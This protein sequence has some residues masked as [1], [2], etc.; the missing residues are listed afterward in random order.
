MRWNDDLPSVSTWQPR[1][2][3]HEN[4]R[5]G[6]MIT[7]QAA[8]TRIINEAENER[9][10][11]IDNYDSGPGVEDIVRQELSKLMPR[12]YCVDA[13]VVNDQK[14]NTAGDI[15]VVVRDQTW[16]TAVKLEAT[17]QSRRSH[18]P[19]EAIYAAVEVKQTLGF[20][21]LDVAM[22]KLVTLSRLCRPE[23]PFGHITE[24]QHIQSLNKEG[25]ILNPLHTTVFG[26]KIQDGVEFHDIARRFDQINACL[27]R[28]HMVTM[29]CI[30]DRGTAWYSV[31]SG[32]PYNATFMTDRG[33][34]LILHVNHREPEN[35][36]YRFF[37]LL[38]GHLGRSVLGI[39]ELGAEYGSPPPPRHTI[40]KENALYNQKLDSES[41]RC[42]GR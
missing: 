16:T 37:Q 33:E 42:C 23:N 39:G 18:F 8:Q 30:L 17:S 11:N 9:K 6:L 32:S 29:L 27:N 19:F 20:Q 7:C 13:G 10:F 22:E 2:N 21:Q 1:S 3:R 25:A 35:A 28:D 31:K 15:D 14:G 24:N 5:T 4:L 36:F 26:T 38:L 40:Y 12:R 41:P 34:P